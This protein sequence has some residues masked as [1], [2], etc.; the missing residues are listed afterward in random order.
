MFA[1]DPLYIDKTEFNN[2]TS[3]IRLQAMYVFL[4][5][6]VCL[7]FPV[8]KYKII[9]DDWGRRGKVDSS[10]HWIESQQQIIYKKRA[11][12]T[13][14]DIYSQF[15]CH[16]ICLM[17]YAVVFETIQMKICICIAIQYDSIL[18]RNYRLVIFEVI[19]DANI[20]V[21]YF[22]WACVFVFVYVYLFDVWFYS[23]KRK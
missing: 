21:T 18:L 2:I 11:N 22:E 6:P 19:L 7:P 10:M 15:S 23:F 9:V 13:I 1:Q 16:L 14:V 20:F 8:Y 5:I 4:S 3:P 12:S 17:S